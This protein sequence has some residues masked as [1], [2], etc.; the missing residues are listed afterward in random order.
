MAVLS[1]GR[2]TL[3]DVSKRYTP[4]GKIDPLAELLSQ[5][6]DILED[7]VM[8]EANQPTSHVVNIRTGLPTVYWR[9]YNAGV[10]SSKSTSA[11]ITEPCAMMEAR[12]TIDAKLLQ[13]NG[14]GPE[15][16]LSE[17]SAFIEA[18]GQEFTGK[19]FN[20]NV[21]LDPKTFTGLAT[22]YSSTSAGNGGNVILGGG[23]GS[24]N[25]SMYL[26]VWGPQTVFCTYPKGSK[27][28]LVNKDLGIQQVADE[29]GNRFEAMESLF[30]WDC[31]LVVK[32]WRYAIRIANI[33][34][35]DWV[36]VTG[37][38]AASAS[39]NLL[40]LM[41]RAIARI[42]NMNMGRAAFYA[43]RSIREGL[44]IQALDKSNAAL[45]VQEALTQF[46][47]TIHEL[48]YLGIPIRGVDGLGIAETLVS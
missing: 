30:Q 39:T 2:L 14:G 48:R 1:T 19:L 28:G 37:S 11:Q 22:R 18:M 47:N 38:Q 20:G 43:N 46:G 35:S 17:E 6:N 8:V 25:A 27:A 44:M 34:V 24:D 26:I 10:P 13:L 16:R 4:D 36:G 21:G 29:S 40:K 5:Q 45:G 31:G 9:S 3:A 7:V 33:D 41:A 42:P 32:D 15:F 23:A 12:S